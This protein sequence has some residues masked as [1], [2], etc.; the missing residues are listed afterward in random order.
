[1][2]RADT[3]LQ[4]HRA[5]RLLL[6]S[7][8]VRGIWKVGLVEAT[9]KSGSGWGNFVRHVF[10]LITLNENDSRGLRNLGSRGFRRN[11]RGVQLT[12]PLYGT[13]TALGVSFDQTLI[14][15][16]CLIES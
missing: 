4:K 16:I 14:A 5:P 11:Q 1:M 9:P 15:P 2:L 13:A 6:V 12:S 8:G 7:G 10:I 3:V